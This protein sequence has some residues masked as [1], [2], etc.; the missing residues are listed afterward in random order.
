MVELGGFQYYQFFA[1]G[2]AH[3]GLVLEQVRFVGDP[4]SEAPSVSNFWATFN[5]YL[6]P[7]LLF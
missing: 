3:F 2:G 4:F 6:D 1:N 7:C 5:P